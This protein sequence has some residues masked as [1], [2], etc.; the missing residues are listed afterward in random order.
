MQEKRLYT[1]FGCNRKCLLHWNG[2]TY[3]AT[4]QN[5][6]IMSLGLNF[7][8]S[9]PDVKIGDDCVISLYDDKIKYQVVRID[10]FGIA[11]GYIDKLLFHRLNSRIANEVPLQAPL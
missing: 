6:S 10:N 9:R 8:G 4:I 11:L 5:M 2:T 7:D 3:R 1:R